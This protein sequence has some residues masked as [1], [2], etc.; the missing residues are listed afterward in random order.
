MINIPEIYGCMVFNDA[1][2]RQRLPKD[3]YKSLTETIKTGK[4]IDVSIANVVANAMKDW[5]TEK[6]ATH[7]THWFQ[8]LTSV[9]A[10]KH[11]S[12]ISPIGGDKVV[13]EFSGKELIKGESDAS[14]FPSGGL[15]E[16]CNARGYTAWDPSSY[17][18]IKDGT[19]YIPTVFCSYTGDALDTKTPLLRSMDVISEQALRILAL[20][21]DTTATRV[22][23]SVG[24]EQEY[25]LINKEYYDKRDDLLY[26]GRTLFG[27]PAPKG[28]QLE[29][30]YYGHLKTKIGAYMEDLD[31]ELWKLGI[32]SK[33][34]HNEV[35]PSQHELA[36]IFANTNV[37]VDQNLIIMETMKTVAERHG[38][39][40][41][42]HEKPYAGI[43]GSGKHNNWSIGTDTGK[44]LLSAGKNP[45]ANTQFLLFLAAVIAAVDDYQDLLRLSAATPGNDHRLGA[46]EAPPAIVSMFLGDELEE[47]IDAIVGDTDYLSKG[48]KTMD[49]G[50][51]SVPTFRYDSTDRNR[52]SPFAFTGNKFEFRMVGSSQ[53][54]AMSNIVIN[55]AVAKA[56]KNF[57]DKLEGAKDLESAARALIKETF[58]AHH[59]IIFNGNGYSSAWPEEAERRGLLNMRT[60]VDSFSCLT[61]EKNVKLF[62][63]FGVMSEIEL[64]AREEI[65]FENYSKVIDI[66]AKT[67][68]DIAN[69]K[70]IPAVEEY[71]GELA[72]IAKNKMKIFETGNGAVL[73][74]T[75]IRK[76]SDLN[77]RAYDLAEKLKTA[78]MSADRERTH[79]KHYA[80]SAMAYKENVRP[81]M[82]ELRQVVDEMEGIVP[83]KIWPLPSYGEMTMKQ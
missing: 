22:N 18:F 46:N 14:S 39:V 2:M 29:D 12:F 35:A 56:L 82:T 31:R 70:I 54:I 5:A 6:G 61:A 45:S 3:V 23:T 50:V 80:E 44:N 13:M 49:L 59:R 38:L 57:A 73:E 66:E 58:K 7:Y 16:T 74:K 36:P 81:I 26:T 71:I 32:N 55:T 62:T 21:G 37:A 79:K 1:V 77:A 47:L 17:A 67:M 25:F 48:K 60:S 43:N 83:S 24:A 28:Q 72:E 15:R 19:L 42:L 52:T 64:R 41:L 76:L 51:P 78:A 30:H 11:D 40:A 4:M 8:P 63:E 65:Y 34:K 69:K 33:T 10:E 53:N 20:F 75:I 27:A 9:T 68:V